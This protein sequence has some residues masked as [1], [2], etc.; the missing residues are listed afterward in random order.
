[1]RRPTW[2]DTDPVQLHPFANSMPAVHSWTI[3]EES[4]HDERMAQRGFFY[5]LYI[6]QF[7]GKDGRIIRV[8]R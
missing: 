1:M 6:C 4:P 5:A 2:D 7:K 3:D 8:W